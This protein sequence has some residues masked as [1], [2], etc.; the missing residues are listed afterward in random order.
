MIQQNSN[1][2]I[3]VLSSEF[4]CFKSTDT[5]SGSDLSSYYACSQFNIYVFLLCSLLWWHFAVKNWLNVK[6]NK[7]DTPHNPSEVEAW[8]NAGDYDTADGACQVTKYNS[9]MENTFSHK[10]F[11]TPSNKCGTVKLK[12]SAKC[13]RSQQCLSRLPICHMN[14]VILD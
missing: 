2:F 4:C 8:I 12:C 6:F 1:I 5:D 7:Q 13:S 3:Q 9:E 11:N 14:S 10:D